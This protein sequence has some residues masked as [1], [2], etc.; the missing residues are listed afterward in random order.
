MGT[1]S[2]RGRLIGLAL[3]LALA[4]RPQQAQLRIDTTEVQIPVSV[5]DAFNRPIHGLGRENFRIFDEGVEQAI[6]SLGAED[7][8]VAVGLL[9]DKSGS[10][11]NNVGTSAWAVK[12]FLAFA[13]PR[14]EFFLVDFDSRP[15]LMIP[16]TSSANAAE[17]SNQL[18]FV[19]SEGM[20]AL[21][22]AI[23]LSVHEMRKS[24]K[25]KKALLI[26]SDGGDNH[27][28]FTLTQVDRVLRESDAMIYAIG[29]YGGAQQGLIEEIT[30]PLFL[31]H[32]TQE[33]GGF[34]YPPSRNSFKDLSLEL[35]DRYVLGFSPSEKT[36]DGRYHHL[37][38]T[39]VPP[40]G[41]PK[42]KLHSRP[43]YYATTGP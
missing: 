43:G 11:G 33:T 3:G 30:G 8:D 20:T 32:L 14:D 42:L 21:L 2:K 16:L 1:P 5:T 35:R 27:S 22:D 12:Q 23:E 41:L 34:V 37:K 24:T 19:K 28:R 18:T 26:L 6:T 4:G 39:V 29:E 38:V 13:N 31:R 7:E 9:V 36:L 15:R 10:M 40:K 17:I 25:R